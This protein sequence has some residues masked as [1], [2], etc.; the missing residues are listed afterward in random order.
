MNGQPSRVDVFGA[1]KQEQPVFHAK[2]SGGES[3]CVHLAPG[4]YTIVASSD[5]FNGPPPRGPTLADSKEC[6]SAPRYTDLRANERLTL[7]I[8]PVF[9]K[10]NG[11]GYS[12]CGWDVLP[13]GTPQP[14]NCMA[15]PGLPS[16]RS[17]SASPRQGPTTRSTGRSSAT[18]V[19][20]GRS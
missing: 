5:V 8:W 17:G 11:G 12:G 6:K 7:D 18:R 19:R 2:L 15:W 20:A 10:S 14:S 16:C 13:T 1:T 9:S 4:G 3:V